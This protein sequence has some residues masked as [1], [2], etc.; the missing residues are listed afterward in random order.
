[1]AISK[2]IGI[3]MPDDFP[4]S[5]HDA[6]GVKLGPYQ[7]GNPEVWTEYGGGWN[8]IAFRFKTAAMA[9]DRFRASTMP[10]VRHDSPRHRMRAPVIAASPSRA[11]SMTGRS[12]RAAR[13]ELTNATRSNNRRQKILSHG[14]ALA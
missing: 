8:A 5:A 3:D 10:K 14:V 11:G 6:V 13:A 1:M 7:P 2:T 9:D 4:T 12:A